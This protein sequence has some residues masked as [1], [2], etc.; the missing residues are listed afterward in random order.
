MDGTVI[1]IRGYPTLF[2]INEAKIPAVSEP[3]KA[4]AAGGKPARSTNSSLNVFAMAPIM[5]AD[6]AM[7]TG[8]LN[9]IENPNTP[10]KLASNLKISI[11]Y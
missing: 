9:I 6:V 7:A 4:A 3:I 8:L 5:A 11:E 2:F 1:E 10:P